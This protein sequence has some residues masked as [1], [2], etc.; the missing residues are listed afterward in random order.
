MRPT[1]AEIDLSAV[2]Y[3][4]AQIKKKVAPADIMA[5]VKADGYGHGMVQVAR[6][7]VKNGINFFAVEL[8]EEAV[9]LREN[10]ITAPILVFGFA[11]PELT[12]V[13]VEHDL[14]VTIYEWRSAEALE[15]A[16]AAAGKRVP[17]HIN[18]DTGMGRAGVDWQ[19]AAALLHRMQSL[20]HINIEGIYTHYPTSDERDRSF[21]ELQIARLT[22]VLHQLEAEGI[23]IPIVHTAN[24]GAILDLPNSYFNYVR[25]DALLYGFYPS[26]ETSESIDI[27]PAMSIKSQVVQMKEI[28]RGTSVGYGRTFIAEAP[29]KITT[30]PMGYADGYRH[31]LSNKGEVLIRGRRYPIVG[32]VCMDLIMIDLGAETDVEIGDEVVVLGTQ[33]KESISV[34]LLA[35]KCNTLPYEITCAISKRVP[36]VYLNGD[37]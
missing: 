31:L 6:C 18:V 2:S 3:N 32:R 37:E 19:N 33:G 11:I 13:F 25:P 30:L 7:A 35:E 24:S 20:Q 22:E 26:T 36:R 1:R 9:T 21:A 27:K 5:V 14:T 16:A 15:K 10:E 12:P 4:I 8:I 17:V 28:G 29:T 23:R 34:Y